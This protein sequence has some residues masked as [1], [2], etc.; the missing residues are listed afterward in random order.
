MTH[1]SHYYKMETPY[2]KYF[3]PLV[4]VRG[5]PLMQ[6]KYSRARDAVAHTNRNLDKAKMRRQRWSDRGKEYLVVM[7]KR[8]QELR[9]EA[10]KYT[11]LLRAE[12]D[13]KD[14]KIFELGDDREKM[15]KKIEADIT[16]KESED[17]II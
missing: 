7:K 14:T 10:I 17:E 12:K 2:G 15:I 4:S 9:R 5:F 1:N 6:F 8:H 3:Y 13:A 16:A 11:E